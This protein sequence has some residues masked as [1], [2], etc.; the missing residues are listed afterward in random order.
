MRQIC[1]LSIALLLPACGPTPR[2]IFIDERFSADEVNDILDA[3]DEVNKLACLIGENKLMTVVGTFRDG[4]GR[5]EQH[6]VD[7]GY[8]ELYRIGA[9]SD[10]RDFVSDYEDQFSSFDKLYGFYTGTDIGILV[11]NSYRD[12]R[13]LKHTVMHELGHFVGMKHITNNRHAVMHPYACCVDSFTQADKE[14]FCL[15]H[16]CD[17]D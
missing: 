7:N 11:F 3:V 9:A 17:P 8:N 16:G 2:E 6:N 12:G 13:P 5:F 10:C 14:E 4:N 15:R 1:L